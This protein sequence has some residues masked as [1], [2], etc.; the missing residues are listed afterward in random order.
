MNEFIVFHNITD[1]NLFKYINNLSHSLQYKNVDKIIEDN[2]AFFILHFKN[3]DDLKNIDIKLIT[4]KNFVL[5]IVEKDLLDYFH[6]ISIENRFI[7]CIDGDFNKNLLEINIKGFLHYAYKMYELLIQ[8]Y[9]LEEKI[10]DLAF[11]TT[12]VLE[13]KEIIEDIA[14]RDGMTKLYN[15]A[16]FRDELTKIFESSKNT[17]GVFSLAILD[18]DFFKHVNDKYGHLK[19]DE[20]LKAFAA[21]ILEHI[22]TSK[23]IASRYGGEEFAVIFKDQPINE[24]MQKIDSLRSSFNEK[25]FT[26][27]NSCFKV[28]FSAGATQFHSNLKDTIEMI[29][30]A[31]EALYQSKKDGRNRTTVKLI[32]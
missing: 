25:V 16:Y 21:S 28:T 13:Q 8:N 22:D 2:N 19:G 27:E 7:L 29:K 3:L 26:Y 15:H 20:V 24:A 23:D 11:A 31:D 6:N 17:G 14:I 32:E 5:F 18:L 10:F 30:L 9:E 4:Q 12:D 1:Q